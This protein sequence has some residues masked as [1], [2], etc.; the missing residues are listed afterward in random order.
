M[1]GILLNISPNDNLKFFQNEYKEF[2]ENCPDALLNS[3]NDYTFSNLMKLISARGPNFASL[4]TLKDHRISLFSSVLSLR[5]P[6]CKQSVLVEDRYVLQFNGELYNDEIIHNDTQF[7]V[8]L[9][10]NTEQNSKGII[11]VIKNLDGE[12][13]FSIYDLKNKRLYFGRDPIGKRSLCYYLTDANEL[14]VSSVSG[15]IKGFKNCDAGVIYEYDATNKNSPLT[16]FNNIFED[17]TINDKSDL[18]FKSLQ[19]HIEE[20]YKVLYNAVRKRVLSIHPTHIENSPIAVLFSGGLDCSVI[21]ALICEVIRNEKKKAIIELLNVGFE[22]PRTGL[23]PKDTPDRKLAISSSYILQKL[24]PN[25]PIKLIEVDVP[26]DEYLEKRPIVI[27]LMYPKETEMDLSIAIAFYFASRG[28]GYIQTGSDKR[29]EYRRKGIVLFSGLGADELYGGYHKFV[30]KT[31]RELVEELTRQI[32]N[33][34]DRNLNRDDKVIANNG[35][36]VR[37]PFLDEHVIKYSTHDIPINYKINK[38]ILRKLSLE[39]L[40]LDGI[41][42][43]PKRAIQFGSKSAK[44]TKDGNKNGT[45]KIK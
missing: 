6:F 10:L 18:E 17:F 15:S 32:N 21:V 42:E 14:Y 20:L 5:E 1:C 36:E 4:R 31:P 19:K 13:A 7:I 22:N 38:L 25:V 35:V 41:S 27:D 2:K 45:D 3:N 28:K 43:E 29:I 12:F 23:M 11:S 33:I 24:Y 9:L 34:H 44:M 37:Y 16:I 40:H 8:K 39:M 26:Y 30:N